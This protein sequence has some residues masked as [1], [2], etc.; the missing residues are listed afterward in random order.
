MRNKSSVSHILV[1]LQFTAIVIV[2]WPFVDQA[3]ERTQ[4]LAISAFGLL[5]GV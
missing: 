4:W 1:A 3:D 2:A 5:V